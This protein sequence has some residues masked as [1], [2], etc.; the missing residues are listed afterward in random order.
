MRAIEDLAR[1]LR[2][3]ARMLRRTPAFTATAL[4]VLAVGIGANTAVFSVVNAVLLEPLPYPAPDRIVQVMSVS[5]VNKSVLVSVPKFNMWRSGDRVFA[6]L[7][8]YHAGDPGMNLTGGDRPEHLRAMHVSADYFAVFGARLREGR[9]FSAD[10]DRPNGARVAVISHGLWIRRFGSD[11]RTVG[12]SIQLGGHAY[13]VIGL[14]APGFSPEPAAEIWLPLQ[15]D[16]FS[17]D[18][19]NYLRVAGRLQ[20]GVTLRGARAAVNSTTIPFRRKFPFALEPWE[21]FE[22]RSLR[23]VMVSDAAT[24]LRLL[25]GAVVFVLLIACANVA[26]LLLARGQ[27]RRREIA[28][29]LALGANR[30]RVM[31]QLLTESVLLAFAGGAAGLALGYTALRALLAAA[32]AGIPRIGADG[33]GVAAD[34]TVLLFTLSVSL[35]TGM[36]FGVVPALTAARTELGAAFKD[37]G[38]A[39]EI[40]WRRRRWPAILVAGEITLALVLLVGSGLLI[41]TFIALRTVDRGFDPHNVLTLDVSLSGA[42]MDDTGSLMRYVRNAEERLATMGGVGYV[43]AAR[44]LPLEPAFGLPFMIDGRALSGVGGPFH[45]IA[46]WHSVS[47]QYFDVFR[48]RLR[49]GRTFDRHDVAGARPVAIINETMARRYWQRGDPL[50]DR[51]EIGASAGPEFGDAPRRIVGVVD[52]I[53]DDQANRAPIPLIYVP[54]AQVTDAMTS[55]NNRLYALR[56]SVRTGGVGAAGVA[57][58]VEQELRAAGGG[59]PIARVRTM[60]QVVAGATARAAFSMTLLTTFAAVA[61]LLA[62]VGLYGLMSYSVQ[63]R[64]QEIGIRM[65]LGAVPA[66]VRR[67][68]LVDGLRLAAAGVG[69]GLVAALILTRLMVGLVFGVSTYDPGVFAAVVVLLSAVAL[70]AAYVPARR[71]TRINPL[72]ALR[73]F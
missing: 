2:Y 54:L 31:R 32:P 70:A 19:S 63:Q 9:T 35:G 16:P 60:E 14:L 37:A 49:R 36:L 51:L 26:N 44:S 50:R 17:Q 21:E 7:A 56:W 15:A 40:G 27:R 66:D 29:R 72:T 30:S 64:T 11:P 5:R 68:V 71:V 42:G 13:Q 1:D 12:S 33:S 20:A 45:G 3:A 62:V 69:T 6:A 18:H 57:S 24:A 65:A 43:A 28:T 10:E 41:K 73:G 55:R 58:V 38:S 22:V 46:S 39:V 53:R 47:P 67:M 4:A 48:I 34:T 25:T 23:D 59:L 61:L 8:A 52:D